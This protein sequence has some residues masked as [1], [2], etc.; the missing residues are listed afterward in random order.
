MVKKKRSKIKFHKKFI[1]IPALIIG[2]ILLFISFPILNALGD[3]K[4]VYNADDYNV[5]EL[6]IQDT[7]NN[8]QIN[9]EIDNI[10]NDASVFCTANQ[11]ILEMIAQSEL[12]KLGEVTV[13]NPPANVDPNTFINTTIV[14][15]ET[16]ILCNKEIQILIKQLQDE[17][18][19]T[20][21]INNVTETSDDSTGQQLCDIEPNN[22]LCGTLL[23]E[24]SAITLQA[25]VTKITSQGQR[26]ESISQFDLPRQAFLVEEETNL[27]FRNGFLEI[28]LF[29]LTDPDVE[30]SGTGEL[31]ILIGGSSI[32]TSPFVI[33]VSQENNTGGIIPLDIQGTPIVKFS[34]AQNFNKFTNLAITPVEIRVVSIDLSDGT[35]QFTN[36]NLSLFDIN[37]SRD[38]IQIII[39][40]ES[41]NN[42]RAFPSDSRIVINSVASKS[43]PYLT[44]L[45]R[46]IVF[47]STFYGNGLGCSQPF[48]VSDRT[49]TP[50]DSAT[51]TIP[52]PKITGISLV[53]SNGIT[54][55]TST[56]G[57]GNSLYDFNQITRNATYTIKASGI[58]GVLD[59]GLNQETKSFTFSQDGTANT[60]F[61]VS[62]YGKNYGA[63]QSFTQ[64]TLQSL[65][66]INPLKL[67]VISSNF[68]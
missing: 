38:D 44:G 36:Q 6:S 3:V 55:S 15:Q 7:Q 11:T 8:E 9:E 26:I 53:D 37:I 63:C 47:D 49:F 1:W 18:I 20:D 29:A 5:P 41:G 58:S 59:Y 50:T 35:S 34:F 12:D 67:G 66:M 32:F 2:A 40:D 52:A 65:D 39:Q 24:A 31:D 45:V 22:P 46:Q 57:T 61:S 60:V 43:Q 56:G 13:S 64:S 14:D 42:V 48:V 25:K 28:E 4:P 19:Q 23:P 51:L 27:D 54:I 33:S 17:L 62:I 16:A 30:L 21:P 68:P 10:V